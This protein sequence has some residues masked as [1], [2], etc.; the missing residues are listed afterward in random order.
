MSQTFPK[1]STPI[2]AFVF[3]LILFLICDTSIHRSSLLISTK[4]AVA[5]TCLITSTVLIQVYGTVITSSPGPIPKAS[6]D[7]C[8]AEVQELTAAQS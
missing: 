2:I 4:I 8:N 6:K 5:P 1:R 3:L 7:K